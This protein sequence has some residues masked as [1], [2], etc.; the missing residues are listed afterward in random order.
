MNLGVF[1]VNE[2]SYKP[3]VQ[4]NINYNFANNSDTWTENYFKSHYEGLIDL[5][6]TNI[7]SE[8]GLEKL[9][10]IAGERILDLDEK[11]REQW[12][13]QFQGYVGKKLE[14]NTLENSK[15]M[16]DSLIPQLSTRYIFE[17]ESFK[18]SKDKNY[19]SI[20]DKKRK[21]ET[22]QTAGSSKEN[23]DKY[24]KDLFKDADNHTIQLWG[25]FLP[26]IIEGEM[27]KTQIKMFTELNEYGIGKYISKN[28]DTSKRLIS[29][30]E[31][32][33]KELNGRIGK[34]I[35]E[36][37]KILK[38]ELSPSEKAKINDSFGKTIEEFTKK[39]SENINA[40]EKFPGMISTLQQMTYQ[41][42]LTK[43]K[44]KTENNE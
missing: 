3:A 12:Y 8:K 30:L 2:E 38:R 14:E 32:A 18:D 22:L 6:K 9:V 1:M 11:T 15:K 41:S 28:L 21:L 16:G 13:S 35:A 29:E 26:Q 7:K 31:I 34:T 33:E 17:T 5:S 4:Q 10:N 27:R 43:E 19:T 25:R 36:K 40:R 44:G 20:S 37:Q 24:A 39:Y 42:I 23:M